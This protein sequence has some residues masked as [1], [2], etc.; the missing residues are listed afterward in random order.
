[1]SDGKLMSTIKAVDIELWQINVLVLD[2]ISEI[3]FRIQF[4]KV[5]SD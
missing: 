5:F 4:C 1:M 3:H 2:K